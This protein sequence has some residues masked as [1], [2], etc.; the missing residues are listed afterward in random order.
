MVRGFDYCFQRFAIWLISILARVLFRARRQVLDRPQGGCLLF[1]NHTSIWDFAD[2]LYAVKPRAH[3]RFVA[4][5]EQFE[6]SRLF[7][8]VLT[9]LGLIKK[10]QG[11]QDLNCVREI[12]KAVRA[13]ETVAIYASGMTSFDGRQAWDAL[14]GAGTLA[15]MLKCPVYTALIEGG[16]MSSPRYAH[17]R[18]KGRVDISVRRLLT[19]E[20]SA[21]LS[22]QEIQ[23]RVNA[24]L[25]F[26]E[27][28]WQEKNR[29]PFKP[30]KDLRGITN[31]LYTCPACGGEYTLGIK[32]A[33]IECACGFSAERDAYGF[34]TSD[35][36]ACPRRMDR[37]A[38]MEYAA[39]RRVIE[40]GK[41]ELTASAE[42]SVKQDAGAYAPR[43]K[44]LLRFTNEA[45][46]FTG[47]NESL[48]FAPD[49][50]QFMV[51]NDIDRLR[52]T[53]EGKSYSFVFSDTRVIDKW[54]FA[55]RIL[56]NGVTY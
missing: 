28:D 1:C 30:F 48:R 16:F 33:R 17:R 35:N 29:V 40:E 5:N 6:K 53:A 26:N 44:G 37:W 22:A 46:T 9:H 27:W 2:L 47:E 45:L 34:F 55:H 11:A 19:G 20:E 38:D 54:F 31:V 7:A 12:I 50:F 36:P 41:L 39:L 52:F 43:G 3:F 8:W 49:K 23:T 18:F 15:H 4:T 42:L 25:N 56:V 21:A 32:G 51:L 13:G 10:H 14:P 24:A